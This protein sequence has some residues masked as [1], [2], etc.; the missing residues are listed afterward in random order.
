[1]KVRKTLLAATVICEMLLSAPAAEAANFSIN[2]DDATVDAGGGA[3]FE[4]ADSVRS[5][6]LTLDSFQR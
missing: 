3:Y 4:D 5:S 6:F 1:M 2:F